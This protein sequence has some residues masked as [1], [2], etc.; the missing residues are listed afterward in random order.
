MRSKQQKYQDAEKISELLKKYNYFLI[1]DFSGLNVSDFSN[2]RRKIKQ[3]GG[4]AKVVKKKI[5]IKVLEQLAIT[6]FNFSSYKGSTLLLFGQDYLIFKLVYDFAKKNEKLVIFSGFF[7][8]KAIDVSEVKY[9]AT[10]PSREILYGQLLSVLQAPIR[11][12]VAIL[13]API[14]NLILVLSSISKK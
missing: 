3:A 12:F 10:L 11:N 6:G 9:I 4:F 8:N 5:L 2:L 7:E 14:R 1:C 13:K